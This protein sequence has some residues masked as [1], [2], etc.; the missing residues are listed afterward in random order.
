MSDLVSKKTEF[1]YSYTYEEGWNNYDFIHNWEIEKINKLYT[2]P[3][4]KHLYI[5]TSLD[6]NS[7]SSLFSSIYIDII[8]EYDFVLYINGKIIY[9]KTLTNLYD[10][11]Y[12]NA[13]N[14]IIPISMLGND[15]TLIAIELY[16]ST[17]RPII[18]SSSQ[19]IFINFRGEYSDDTPY[20]TLLNGFG[21]YILQSSSYDNN[22]NERYG[23][24]NNPE[25]VWQEEYPVNGPYNLYG[26]VE[27]TFG[28][29]SYFY[30][31]RITIRNSDSSNSKSY[32]KDVSFEGNNND[33][34]G[35]IKFVEY[36]DIEWN[37]PGQIKDYHL[38]DDDIYFNKVRINISQIQD[39]GPNNNIMSIS[40][41]SFWLCKDS[42]CKSID[43]ILPLGEADQIQ[44]INCPNGQSGLRK[45]VCKNQIWNEFENNCEMSPV[46]LYNIDY[47][48]I[49][50]AN[51]IKSILAT[52][53]CSNCVYSINPL[54]PNGLVLSTINGEIFGYV[55]DIYES[56]SYTIKAQNQYGDISVEVLFVFRYHSIPS[57]T[58]INPDLQLVTGEKYKDKDI[59]IAYGYNLSYSITPSI[60]I[61][62]FIIRFT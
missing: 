6:I 39:Y 51:P 38:D 40:D 50:V 19:K 58:A 47:I 41:I 55:N 22:N 11:T 61:Y 46:L 24:D 29:Y 26:W 54:L 2:I 21:G 1:E 52:I 59:I 15:F 37:S 32:V 57:V 44:T 25:T 3:Y 7:T 27:Y 5:R 31:N 14:L 17:T 23:F 48:E 36:T 4:D 8:T 13:T 53:S 12:I 33:Q 16:S 34:N 42:H 60:Y 62:Y 9:N 20:C 10:K 28:L 43:N 18:I 35:W 56:K 49:I 30:I 45:F